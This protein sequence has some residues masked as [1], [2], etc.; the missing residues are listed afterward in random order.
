M[1]VPKTTMHKSQHSKDIPI[2]FMNILIDRQR[3]GTFTTQ[4]ITKI[5]NFYVNLTN[6][7][8]QPIELIST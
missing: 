1:K 4:F 7:T 3:E 6:T 2:Y 5:N 8:P